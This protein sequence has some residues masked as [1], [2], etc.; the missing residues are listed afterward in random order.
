MRRAALEG[1]FQRRLG[2]EGRDVGPAE[3]PVLREAGEGVEVGLRQREPENG[4]IS[5][6]LRFGFSF[7]R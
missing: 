4:G 1:S 3:A 7:R 5:E 6:L 2:L